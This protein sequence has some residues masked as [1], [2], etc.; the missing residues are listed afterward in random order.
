MARLLID[1]SVLIDLERSQ[2]D[3]DSLAFAYPNVSFSMAAITASELLVGVHLADTG[4][5]RQRRQEFIER[6][7]EAIQIVPFDLRAARQH[8]ITWSQLSKAGQMI[9]ANDLLIGSTALAHGFAV[10]TSDL[11]D[12]PLIPGL[13][14]EQPAAHEG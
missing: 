1:T 2:R 11:R 10:L 5:Q 4:A 7:L 6:L 12:F 13:S 14:I 9:K 8:A 3:V